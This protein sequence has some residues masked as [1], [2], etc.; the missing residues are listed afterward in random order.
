MADEVRV[1]TWLEALKG[2]FKFPRFGGSYTFDMTGQGGGVPGEII[3]G[4]TEQ[5]VRFSQLDRPGWLIMFNADDEGYVDWGFGPG[6]LGSETGTGTGTT[7]DN[8][9]GRMEAGE[10]ALFRLHPAAELVFRGSAEG[11]RV[12]IFCLED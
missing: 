6:P 4:V 7:N 12:Q 11:I 2:A 1:T 8:L 5:T 3:V 10:P 9:G